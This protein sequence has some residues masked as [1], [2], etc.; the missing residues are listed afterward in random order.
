[1]AAMAVNVFFTAVSAD[2]LSRHDMLGWINDSLQSNFG[3]IEE[4]CSGAAYCQFMDMLFPDHNCVQMKK[5]KFGAMHEHEFLNNFKI[6]QLSFKKMGVDKFVPIDKL[7]KGKFQDNFEFVQWFKRFFDANYDGCEYDA[8]AM[9]G[10]EPMG[11]GAS[12]LGGGQRRPIAASRP[13]PSRPLAS[14]PAARP[15]QNRTASKP[16]SNNNA[17]Q[18]DELCLQLENMRSTT[19]GVEKERDFYFSKLRDIEI[20][21][22][23]NEEEGP[24]MQSILDILYATDDAEGT[25]VVEEDDAEY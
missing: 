7:V 14:R 16:A 25:P 10:G 3:K 8:L 1:I 17:G 20:L 18:I 9:R 5:V 12:K 15:T 19:E 22:Q 13:A 2:S 21:C 24:L 4:L 6:L 23:Q 11:K